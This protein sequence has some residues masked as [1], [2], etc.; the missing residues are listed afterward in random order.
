MRRQLLFFVFCILTIGL[1]E[2]SQAKVFS[3]KAKGYSFDYNDTLWRIVPKSSEKKTAADVDAE[4]AKRTQVTVERNLSDDKYHTRFSVVIDDLK[5]YK[6]TP[7][8]QLTQYYRDALEFLKNQRFRVLSTGPVKLA[9]YGDSAFEIVATQRDFGLTTRQVILVQGG[10]A[11]LLTASARNTVY[12]A[13]KAEIE[14]F[15]NSFSVS[16]PIPVTAR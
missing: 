2:T 13:Q 14:P 3:D 9:K 5:K 7:L 1:L 12:D 15:F 6:G 4:M 10:E 8:E 11:Y 16:S